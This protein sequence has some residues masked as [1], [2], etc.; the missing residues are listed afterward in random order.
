MPLAA[1]T[2]SPAAPLRLAK[3][4]LSA[5]PTLSSPGGQ[6]YLGVAHL[7]AMSDDSSSCQAMQNLKTACIDCM[8]TANRRC[9]SPSAAG[10]NNFQAIS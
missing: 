7:H 4:P 9:H 2:I 3:V 5:W 1:V 8:S 10:L 6:L